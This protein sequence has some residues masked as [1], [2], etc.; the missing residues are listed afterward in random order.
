MT[1]TLYIVLAITLLLLAGLI[2]YWLTQRKKQARAATADGDEPAS[3]GDEIALLIREA[4]GRLAGPAGLGTRGP[5]TAAMTPA[6]VDLERHPAGG[7]P[8]VSCLDRE[9]HRFRPARRE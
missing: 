2:V 7:R 1:T 3:T 4:E 6:A 8:T 5:R 9:E